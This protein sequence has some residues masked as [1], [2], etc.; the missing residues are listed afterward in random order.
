MR[1]KKTQPPWDKRVYKRNY[2]PFYHTA[3]WREI[4]KAFFLGTTTL[5]DGR[6]V[7]NSICLECYKQD[8]ITPSNT[9]DHINRIKS[10]GDAYDLNNMQG[11]CRACHDRKSSKEG[12][13]KKM[14]INSKKS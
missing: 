12:L 4:R 10:G 6:I 8:K 13:D 7:P 11:L 3:R 5:E 9:V 14:E 1:I 2:E